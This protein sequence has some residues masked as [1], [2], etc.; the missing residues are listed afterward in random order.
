LKLHETDCENEAVWFASFCVTK[1]VGLDIANQQILNV[2]R[3]A[4]AIFPVSITDPQK[5]TKEKGISSP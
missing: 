1:P 3:L 5:K 2:N 4:S